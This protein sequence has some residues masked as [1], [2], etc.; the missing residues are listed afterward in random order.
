MASRQRMS[1]SQRFGQGSFGRDPS[2]SSSEG[3]GKQATKRFN[4]SEV[5][6]KDPLLKSLQGKIAVGFGD[7]KPWQRTNF[8]R[9]VPPIKPTESGKAKKVQ[10]RPLSSHTTHSTFSVGGTSKGGPDSDRPHSA[11]TLHTQCSSVC[12]HPWI[13]KPVLTPI[14]TYDKK[15]RKTISLIKVFIFSPF[16]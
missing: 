7:Y 5:F 2:T 3:W 16:H 11:M 13:R 12:M 1:S 10:S 8:P 15:T 4:T 6:K 14:N 9:Y